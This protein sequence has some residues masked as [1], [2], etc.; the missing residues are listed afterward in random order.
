VEQAT[1]TGLVFGTI[2]AWTR[3]IWFVMIAHTAF[4]LMALGMIYYN[5]EVDIAHFFFK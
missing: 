3:S 4:D 2:F 5:L 1:I